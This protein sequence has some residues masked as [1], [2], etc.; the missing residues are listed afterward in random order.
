[1]TGDEHDTT[2]SSEVERQNKRNPGAFGKEACTIL[3]KSDSGGGVTG[4]GCDDR[5]AAY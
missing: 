1:M 3:S 2:R 5:S 4:G